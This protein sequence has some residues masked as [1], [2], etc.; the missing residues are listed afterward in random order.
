M[1]VN[2]SVQTENDRM[3]EVEVSYCNAQP[4]VSSTKQAEPRKLCSLIDKIELLCNDSHKRYLPP[5]C[6]ASLKQTKFTRSND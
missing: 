6:E 1:Q 5:S 2:Q 3:D 4:S